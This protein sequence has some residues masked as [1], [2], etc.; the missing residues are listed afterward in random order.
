MYYRSLRHTITQHVA[1][2][3]E[4][5]DQ[6][7]A[8]DR[9][10]NSGGIVQLE[11]RLVENPLERIQRIDRQTNRENGHYLWHSRRDFSQKRANLL[12]SISIEDTCH[13]EHF[14]SDRQMTQD[15]VIFGSRSLAWLALVRHPDSSVFTSSVA[16]FE[17]IFNLDSI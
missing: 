9:Y 14:D 15:F 11:T 10:V 13:F 4:R 8:G 7:I 1:N 6:N 3:E 17:R 12:Q 2:D 5:V 16:Q